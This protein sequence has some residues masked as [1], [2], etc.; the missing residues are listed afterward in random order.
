M[1]DMTDKETA[2]HLRDWVETNH[3]IFAWPT[4]ACGYDQH[5]KFAKH[6]NKN[7][8]GQTKEEFKQFVLDYAD[9]KDKEE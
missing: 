5:I 1:K 2:E 3:G 7:W 9:S 8:K 6:R 4:D